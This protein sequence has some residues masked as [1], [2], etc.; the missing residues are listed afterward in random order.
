MEKLK[1]TLIEAQKI[2]EEN[3]GDLDL[4]YSSIT[5]LPDGL[6]VDG[7]LNLSYTPITKLP[8]DIAVCGWIDLSSSS[9]T[10]LPDN[11]TVDYWLDLSETPIIELPKG[12]TVGDSIYL[13]EAKIAELPNELVVSG[14]L[15]LVG[16]NITEL[17]KN[18]TVGGDLYLNDNIKELNDTLKVGGN[19]YP[20][21]LKPT[22]NNKLYEGDYKDN[23][24][25]Y[26]DGHITFITRKKEIKGYTY[27][28]GLF[29]NKNVVYDGKNYALCWNFKQ[30]VKE[31]LYKETMDKS[32][33]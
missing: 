18:L 14:D 1:L 11:L 17:P 16:T 2:M 33:Y 24:Y 22:P 8:N 32:V 13:R 29:R 12:L 23:K 4:H 31:L 30:G 26:A 15:D 3:D 6:L 21:S 28:K 5:E 10:K 27:Y 9:I 25:I 19:I 20:P 7:N